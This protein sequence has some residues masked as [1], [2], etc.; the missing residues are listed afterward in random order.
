MI[1]INQIGTDRAISFAVKEL[2]KYVSLMDKT[3]EVQI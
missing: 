3:E 2:E 1:K